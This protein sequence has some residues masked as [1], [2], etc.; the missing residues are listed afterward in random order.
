[1]HPLELCKTIQ[2]VRARPSFYPTYILIY[3]KM[4]STEYKT[5]CLFKRSVQCFWKR[6]RTSAIS[7]MPVELS[8]ANTEKMVFSLLMILVSFLKRWTTLDSLMQTGVMW[9]L[10]L[11]LLSSQEPSSFTGPLKLKVMCFRVIKITWVLVAFNFR[12]LLWNQLLVQSRVSLASNRVSITSIPPF[13]R[14]AL[15]ASKSVLPFKWKSF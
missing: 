13:I 11:C 4:G 6:L 2:R 1:M 5:L 9:R 8:M 15:S 3:Q 10:Q 7:Y 12:R 14:A